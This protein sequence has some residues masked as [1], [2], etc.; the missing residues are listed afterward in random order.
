MNDQ[1]QDFA[2]QAVAFQK[3]WLE[4]M[5]RLTQSAF[6]YSPNSASPE[7]AREVRD[8][9]FKALSQS[10][11]EYLRSPQFQ[12]SMKQWV[13]NTVAFREASND[14]MAKVR[15]E[16]QAP[17]CEDIEAVQL[18][19]RHLERRILDRLETLSKQIDDLRQSIGSAAPPA[20]QSAK[21]EP[22]QKN[23]KSP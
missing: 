22:P 20:S 12:L 13:D 15:Q 8:G 1:S 2:G 5:S 18:N 6:A 9:M 3:I 7:Y 11:D 19:V 14:F 16:L 17:S 10:W 4:S 21:T 23:K